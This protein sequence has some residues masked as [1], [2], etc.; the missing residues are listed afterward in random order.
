M[1]TKRTPTLE[2]LLDA[3]RLLDRV[4]A[5][6][7]GPLRD[8]GFPGAIRGAADPWGPWGLLIEAKRQLTAYCQWRY[9]D[10]GHR[11]ALAVDDEVEE[12]N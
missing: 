12:T 11:R 2:E 10:E 5:E 8:D 1:T 9:G 3:L 6:T 7:A 4:A